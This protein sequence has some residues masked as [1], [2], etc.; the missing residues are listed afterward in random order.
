M[1]SQLSSSIIENIQ[2]LCRLTP[3]SCY[4]FFFF[5]NRNADQGLVRSETLLRSLLSQLAYRCDSI[6]AALRDVYF[7]QGKGYEQPSLKSLRE[8]LRHVIQG[9]DHV[10]LMVDA[11]DECI[12]GDRLQLLKDIDSMASWNLDNLHLMFT[13]RPDPIIVNNLQL[14]ER[15]CC[16]Q[17]ERYS[18]LPDI[19]AYIDERLKSIWSWDDSIRGEVKTAL[20]KRNEGMCVRFLFPCN[21]RHTTEVPHRFRWIALQINDLSRHLTPKDIK[22]QL[23]MLPKD[24]EATYKRALLESQR[25]NQLHNLRLMLQWLTFS[26]RA[27]TL[28]ELADVVSVTFDTDDGPSYDPDSKYCNPKVALD[29]CS[30]FITETLGKWDVHVELSRF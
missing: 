29:V 20:S 10:Y 6:A 18:T 14:I 28:T 23:T 19:E 16:V 9:M 1:I 30:G 7:H 11:L 8:A 2:N 25:R 15:L 12:L 5:D 26:A 22:K 27:M 21:N 4:A 13:S 17:V 3:N 24:L